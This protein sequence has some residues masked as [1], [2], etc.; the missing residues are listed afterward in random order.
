MVAFPSATTLASYDTQG[1]T[2]SLNEISGDSL[3]GAD[4]R[5]SE[6]DP[7]AFV[8]FMRA[9]GRPVCRIPMSVASLLEVSAVHAEIEAELTIMNEVPDKDCWCSFAV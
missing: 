7:V 8:T 9:D 6:G 4:G 1:H 2:I 3:Y 5:L